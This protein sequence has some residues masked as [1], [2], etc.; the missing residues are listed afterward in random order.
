MEH[1]RK[2]PPIFDDR[3][4]GI[5]CFCRCPITPAAFERKDVVAAMTSHSSAMCCKHHF[6][7]A[8]NQQAPTYREALQA[9]AKEATKIGIL[10][11][12]DALC[13]YFGGK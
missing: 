3:F 4:W 8:D 11:V 1:P 2:L 7:G 13:R 12:P 9:L 6:A 10:H 5:C